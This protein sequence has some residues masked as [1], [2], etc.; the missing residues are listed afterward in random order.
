M[1]IIF[2]P[3]PFLLLKVLFRKPRK[4]VALP[5]HKKFPE[6]NFQYPAETG[7]DRILLNL[8]FWSYSSLKTTCRCFHYGSHLTKFYEHAKQD[9]CQKIIQKI[10]YGYS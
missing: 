3:L 4:F 8:F 9:L 6:F 5:F 2:V 10:G 1:S 7:L